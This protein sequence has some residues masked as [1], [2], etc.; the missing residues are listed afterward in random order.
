VRSPWV[1]RIILII[2]LPCLILAGWYSYRDL[3]TLDSP[4]WWAL[5]PA[6]MLN[7]AGLWCAARSWDTL[8]PAEI[9]RPIADDAFYTSQLTKYSPVGGAAQALSQ[10]ALATTDE[11]S[12]AKAAT[13]MIVSKLTIAVAGGAFGPVLAVSHPDL[14]SWARTLL[15]LTPMSLLLGQHSLLRKAVTVAA[16]TLKKEADHTILPP[17]SAV[18]RSIAWSVGLLA[19]SGAAFAVLAVAAGLGAN[20]VQAM[21]GFALAWVIGFLVIP[22]P[23]GL[24][25]REAAVVVLVAGDPASKVAAAVMF[26]VAVVVTEAFMFAVVKLRQRRRAAT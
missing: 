25:V 20:F 24:G 11:V 15:F 23:A 18:W 19:F 13:A 4:P 14:S 21:A 8:L 26:R 5:A 1:R 9:D 22:V 3:G 6:A 10:A 7:L 17:P 16:R 2:G 12:A